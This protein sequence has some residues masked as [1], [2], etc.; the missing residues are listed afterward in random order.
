MLIWTKNLSMK[1]LIRGFFYLNILLVIT[2]IIVEYLSSEPSPINIAYIAD[3][4]SWF[5]VLLGIHGYLYNKKYFS[6]FFWKSF[7]IFL[8]LLELSIIIRDDQFF[9]AEDNIS[10]IIGLLFYGVFV[11]LEV[12][13]IFQYIKLDIWLVK[14][15]H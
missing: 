13:S 12:L 10:L 11:L 3:Y 7:I 1:R 15:D 4:S 9:V 14:N 2:T 6:L 8:T 5:F